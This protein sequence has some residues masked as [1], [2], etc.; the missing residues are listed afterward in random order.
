MLYPFAIPDHWWKFGKITLWNL[1]LNV[2]HKRCP[3]QQRCISFA[4]LKEHYDG[5]ANIFPKS[6]SQTLVIAQT[7]PPHLPRKLTSIKLEGWTYQQS[8]KSFCC[9]CCCERSQFP[10]HG[11]KTLRCGGSWH[12][13]HPNYRLN[14]DVKWDVKR[15]QQSRQWET[16][17]MVHYCLATL[18]EWNPPYLHAGEID[19][20]RRVTIT[21]ALNSDVLISFLALFDVFHFEYISSTHAL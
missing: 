16:A 10:S 7:P 18:I 15:D 17:R 12:Q 19:F 13:Q 5:H 1:S 2:I 14:N 3:V 4:L 8:E 9:C 11:R 6:T 21:V 20:W